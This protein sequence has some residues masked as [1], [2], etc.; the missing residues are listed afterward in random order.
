MRA[1]SVGLRSFCAVLL[2]S[3]P[4]C[5]DTDVQQMDDDIKAAIE[6]AAVAQAKIN[7]E[8][9]AAAH[10]AAAADMVRGAQRG[11]SLFGVSKRS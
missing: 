10:A 7:E 1:P 8:M 11:A 4:Q 9:Q 5:M 2:C 3:R 6:A